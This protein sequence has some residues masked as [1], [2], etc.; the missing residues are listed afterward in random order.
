MSHPDAG[1]RILESLKADIG[2]AVGTDL[3]TNFLD[4]RESRG[5]FLLLGCI[6]S[7]ET[8]ITYRRRSYTDMNLGCPRLPKRIQRFSYKLPLS[9]A[10][11]MNYIYRFGWNTGRK[12]SDNT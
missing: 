8:R 5:K 9:P 7:I 1:S 12:C 4:G 10:D 11:P 3:T 2:K 6:D